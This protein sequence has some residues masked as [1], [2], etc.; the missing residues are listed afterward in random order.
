MANNQFFYDQ[1]IRRYLLQFVRMFSNF[2]VQTGKDRDGNTAL[3]RV[4][5][6]YADISRQSAQ[7]LRNNSENS[8]PNTPAITVHINSL[9]HDK[10][11]IQ[12]PNFVDKVSL[13]QRKYNQDLDAYTNEQGNAIT[14]ERHMPSPYRLEM[15][16]D[17]WTSNT[18]QKLQLLEQILCLFN[19]SLELQTTDNYVDW[20][21]LTQVYLEDVTWS[22]RSIPVGTEDQIDI[23]TL[24]F[25]SPVWISM[26][27]KVKKLGVITKIIASL[28]DE[29]GEISDEITDNAL[30][31]GTRQYI[32]PMNYGVLLLGNSLKLLGPYEHVENGKNTTGVTT[33]TEQDKMWKGLIDQYGVLENGISQVRITQPNDSYV[34]GTVAYHPTDP[35]TL[36]FNVDNDTIPSNTLDSV[37]SIIDPTKSIPGGA[38]PVASANQRYLI[39]NDIGDANNI[40]GADA[41]KSTNDV[42]LVASAFDIIEYDGQNWY[43]VFDASEHSQTEYVT[44]Q[45]TGIQY[46]WTGSEWI[47]SYEGEY[48]NG[49]WSL[50]L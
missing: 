40:D 22:S 29:D 33:K 16:V 47:K 20:T 44:N 32:T 18:E 27:V 26:P 4:P 15:N 3:I 49:E 14:I 24:R 30:L 11:R 34:V 39:L 45:K 41:W 9:T 38:L 35:Y 10:E 21:S 6:R 5:V 7:I 2:Q 43:V 48:T 17:I 46:K 28:Y 36:I 25:S 50:V 8:M 31:L 12:E 1:Q 19:P 42:D 13:R 23:S 37:N